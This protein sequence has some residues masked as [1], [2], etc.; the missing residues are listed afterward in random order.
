MNYSETINMNNSEDTNVLFVRIGIEH[1]DV[2]TK[3]QRNHHV[4]M[5]N[6]N[7][8]HPVVT[9]MRSMNDEYETTLS[10]ALDTVAQHHVPRII[11]TDPIT[12]SSFYAREGDILR[13][14]PTLLSHCVDIYI[15]DKDHVDI[16]SLFY[17]LTTVEYNHPVRK[18]PCS[19]NKKYCGYVTPED[20][21][22]LQ[23]TLLELDVHLLHLKTHLDQLTINSATKK[24]KFTTTITKSIEK[25]EK[26]RKRLECLL[27]TVPV[28]DDCKAEWCIRM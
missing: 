19:G 3:L 11:K 12:N 28:Q 10:S 22:Y 18:Y 6:L 9:A 23:N 26:K 16:N 8:T 5:T 25:I 24:K 1:N 13:V 20:M 21:R 7:Q 4:L 27:E 15:R 17:K 14:P 2:K